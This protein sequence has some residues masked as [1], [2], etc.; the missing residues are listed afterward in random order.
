MENKKNTKPNKNKKSDNAPK[1]NSYWIYGLVILA[2][3][4]I[5]LVSLTGYNKEPISM[6]RFGKNGSFW[7]YRPC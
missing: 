6:K 7:R 4:G 1:F 2:L 3:I 5:N